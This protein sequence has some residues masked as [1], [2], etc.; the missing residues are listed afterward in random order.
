M[1][2]TFEGANIKFLKEKKMHG[3]ILDN[4]KKK[5]SDPFDKKYFLYDASRDKYR[6][7]ENQ[8]VAF[9]GEHYD[10][11]K[12]KMI[13][14]YK[15]ESCMSCRSRNNC[16]KRK[17]GIRYL[18]MYPWEDE[19]NATVAKM[20]TPEAKEIYKLRQQLV[21]P[22]IGDIKE[23]Q[24]LRAFLNRGIQGAKINSIWHVRQEI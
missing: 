20:K 11:Q 16:T 8:P 22:A 14:V 24:G 10:K 23:N 21:E 17:D 6:C 3:Y 2:A 18:K 13:R 5:K 19:R 15:G 12:K 1:R 9:M 7:P 4:N